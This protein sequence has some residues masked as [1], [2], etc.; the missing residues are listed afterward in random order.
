M[1]DDMQTTR[2]FMMLCNIWE[3]KND[4]Q[5]FEGKINRRHSWSQWHYYYM[6]T[7]ALFHIEKK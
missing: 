3:L 6:Y 5:K 2:P 1:Q 4:I 7:F